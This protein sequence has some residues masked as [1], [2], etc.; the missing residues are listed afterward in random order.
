MA[1]HF[2]GLMWW[3]WGPFLIQSSRVIHY[4]VYFAMGMCLGAFGTEIPIFERAGR[5]EE[6]FGIP[7]PTSHST[8]EILETG[9]CNV[10]G[11][12]RKPR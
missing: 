1:I 4:Y 5:A 8:S 11:A 6:M 3:S 9:A 7:F 10:A 2:G 12:M